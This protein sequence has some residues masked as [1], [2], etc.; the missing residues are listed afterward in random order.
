M[1]I[2]EIR[3]KIDTLNDEL[4]SLLSERLKLSEEVALYKAERKLPVVDKEREE[5]VIGLLTEKSGDNAKYIIPV[6]RTIL[7]TSKKLQEDI[8]SEKEGR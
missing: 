4:F 8:I 7:D 1:D 3:C 5:A 2:N 6:F